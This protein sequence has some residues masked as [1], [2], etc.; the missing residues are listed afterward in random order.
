MRA[1][2]YLNPTNW[3]GSVASVSTRPSPTAATFASWVEKRIKYL[4]N[5]ATLR[6]AYTGQTVYYFD[7]IGGADGNSGL[8]TGLPKQTIS[9]ANTLLAA[10]NCRILFKRGTAY[11]AATTGLTIAGSNT[12]IGTYGA[13]KR[14]QVSTVDTAATT[15]VAWTTSGAGNTYYR[16]R[17]AATKVGGVRDQGNNGRFYKRCST[18]AECQALKGSFFHDTG[19]NRLYV[20]QYFDRDLTSA[21]DPTV[22]EIFPEST[23]DGL[24]ITNGTGN[25][26]IKGLEIVG[27]GATADGS[28]NAKYGIHSQLSGTHICCVEDCCVVL[29]NNHNIGQEQ[30]AATGGTLVCIGC[31]AGWLTNNDTPYVCYTNAGGQEFYM[32]DCEVIAGC[33][34]NIAAGA[35]QYGTGSV[36]VGPWLTHTSSGNS[37][38]D[39]AI[40][41]KVRGGECQCSGI[42]GAGNSATFTTDPTSCTSFNVDCFY[43]GQVPG[44][45]DNFTYNPT[46]FILR[47]APYQLNGGNF[48][49]GFTQINI[50][51]TINVIPQF[52]GSSVNVA[53][54]MNKLG[55][56]WINPTFIVDF[57]FIECNDRSAL[58]CCGLVDTST[59]LTCSVHNGHIHIRG[60]DA[61]QA[62]MIARSALT[63]TTG[64]SRNP[65]KFAMKDSIYTIEANVPA[66]AYLAA[67]NNHDAAGANLGT[68][69][70]VN[71]TSNLIA[72]TGTSRG[73]SNVSGTYTN[74]PMWKPGRKPKIGDIDAVQMPFLGGSYYVGY[75]KNWTP[76][77]PGTTAMGPIEAA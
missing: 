2:T 48:T 69:V 65:L 24:F 57:G 74:V 33:V 38:F 8:T 39:V 77:R 36:Q 59:D 61:A 7:P 31:E 3:T 22:I 19:A 15:G 20:H 62:G 30:G 5:L 58:Y 42:G 41:L 28:K 55:G 37:T 56:A 47:Q 9:A 67:G 63:A 34:I 64:N 76:R 40:R 26:H 73:D 44:Q 71:L 75:D 11:T 12:S 54:A 29:N 13:G 68:L 51:Q 6:G 14:C 16:T 1:P 18:V 43:E 27:F 70:I 32:M 4:W 49:D 52:A 66:N 53:A 21:A 45:K 35:P 17:A 23:N 60:V 10:G 46:A 25:T 50:N 72:D